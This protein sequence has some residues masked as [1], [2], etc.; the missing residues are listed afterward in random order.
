MI[1]RQTTFLLIVTVILSW[2]TLG[3]VLVSAGRTIQN[4][5]NAMA[6]IQDKCVLLQI[7]NSKIF[8]SDIDIFLVN[9]DRILLIREKIGP[10]SAVAIMLSE[11]IAT[12]LAQRTLQVIRLYWKRW[13]DADVANTNAAW[14]TRTRTNKRCRSAPKRKK[15]NPELART[16]P[17]IERSASQSVA[18]QVFHASG[19]RQR[20]RLDRRRVGVPQAPTSK[21]HFGVRPYISNIISLSLS[22]SWL[23]SRPSLL[24]LPIKNQTVDYLHMVST[25]SIILTVF[26]LDSSIFYIFAGFLYFF[27]SSYHLKHICTFSPIT[28]HNH[29]NV[30][31]FFITILLAQTVI[32]FRS[33][34]FV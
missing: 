21:V 8:N 19:E 14:H 2:L 20:S 6:I 12:L 28:S 15:K 34:L 17:I 5:I 24:S 26:R 10:M 29:L 11:V 16:N 1:S 31:L 25:I 9:H 18:A 33:H 7:K 4:T 22:H 30:S 13:K 27:I 23:L 32:L 3:F